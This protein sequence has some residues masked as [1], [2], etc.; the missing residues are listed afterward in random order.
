M[1]VGLF[2]VPSP[3]VDFY[4]IKFLDTRKNN[5]HSFSLALQIILSILFIGPVICLFIYILSLV[6]ARKKYL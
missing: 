3:N 2:G 6:K 1:S 4:T 5:F